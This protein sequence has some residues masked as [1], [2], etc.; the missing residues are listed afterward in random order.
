LSR[1]CDERD[2]V[3]DLESSMEKLS[4]AFMHMLAK[5]ADSRNDYSILFMPTCFDDDLKEFLN[6]H[7]VVSYPGSENGGFFPEI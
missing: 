3:D 6:K 7:V 1:I 4:K 2:R 5:A